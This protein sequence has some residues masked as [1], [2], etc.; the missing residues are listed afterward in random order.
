MKKLL[1]II[2]LGLFLSGN[3]YGEAAIKKY[4]VKELDVFGIKVLG[5]KN[6]PDK[7]MKNARD[8]LEQW[9]DNDS[10]KK[11]DNILLVNQLVE[12]N[13]SIA[14][15]KSIRKID[16]ILDKKLI[17]EGISEIQVSRM[18]ALAANEP[19]IAYLEEI[20]HMIT[21]CGYANVYPEVFGEKEG[22]KIALAMD[23]ARGGF[24]DK[25]PKNYPKNA[26]YTY[27]DKY[28]DYSCMITEYFYWTLSS[29]LGLQKNRFD[30]ISEEWKFNTKEKMEKDLLMIRL[31]RNQEF[32]LPKVAPSFNIN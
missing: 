24:F 4:F 31:I 21:S 8:I 18:F 23:K 28:C 19:E 5:L 2:V 11:P 14:M 6:T 15:G 20:L 7:K 13:C 27:D 16:N 9:L 10:D 22:T 1:E 25:V 26:W 12:N 29:Y 32:K 30:E 17:K 3:A